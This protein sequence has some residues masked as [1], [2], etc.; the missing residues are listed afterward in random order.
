MKLQDLLKKAKKG[1][2]MVLETS[3]IAAGEYDAKLVGLKVGD[4]QNKQTGVVS[5]KLDIT[6]KVGKRTIM[7]T[8]YL[9][10]MFADKK[11]NGEDYDRAGQQRSIYNTIMRLINMDVIDD[12]DGVAD[13]FKD[14][15]DAK[16]ESLKKMSESDFMEILKDILDESPK[17]EGKLIVT[18]KKNTQDPTRTDITYDFKAE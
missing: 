3:L 12:I 6:Y 9:G 14:D 1:E 10:W 17:A 15:A 16:A 8:M 7:E 5:P 4:H 11:A 13:F 2:T 18:H